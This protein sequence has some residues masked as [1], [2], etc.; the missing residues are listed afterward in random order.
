[1]PNILTKKSFWLV[2]AAVVILTIV[3]A[4]AFLLKPAA[5]AADPKLYVFGALQ[6]T[7]ETMKEE[8]AKQRDLVE[9]QKLFSGIRAEAS[10][11]SLSIGL[12][13]EG[14]S[15]GAPGLRIEADTNPPGRQAETRF[16]VTMAGFPLAGATMY[17]EGDILSAEAP[18]LFRNEYGIRLETLGRDY[19]Q[20]AFAS[21]LG[22]KLHEGLSVSL[23]PGKADK[24]AMPSWLVEA[25]R[26]FAGEIAVRKTEDRE[27]RV[28]DRLRLCE[29]YEMQAGREAVVRLL[30]RLRDGLKEERLFRAA[31]EYQSAYSDTGWSADGPDAA[32]G[33]AADLPDGDL[34]ALLFIHD[35][36][37][38]R[39]ELHL[40]LKDGEGDGLLVSIQIGGD[41]NLIDAL[42]IDAEA[43]GYSIALKYGGEYVPAE[44]RY[45]AYLVV[46]GADPDDGEPADFFRASGWYAGNLTEN[47]VSMLFDILPDSDGAVQLS[48]SGALRHSAAQ[49]TLSADFGQIYVSGPDFFRQF[50]AA[51]RL[52]PLAS[53]VFAARKPAMLFD[54]S[55]A[56]AG[57]L[58][59]EIAGNVEGILAL[60]AMFM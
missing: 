50:T 55:A 11:Q 43:G 15:F 40:P 45:T 24:A 7:I 17:L 30:N 60:L 20:S 6:K 56:A 25:G 19:N 9:I 48:L 4:A 31:L 28:N 23:W 10:R 32:F 27:V 57:A 29:V 46:Y 16:S 1:M 8:G 26:L 42:W 47:N 51:Y 38:V 33:M 49:K 41:E 18:L 53:P 58:I 37:L 36:R 34:D 12:I 44:S 22:L 14:F 52:E 3:T 54:L 21:L 5:P 2:A 39:A 59:D 35:G 13:E